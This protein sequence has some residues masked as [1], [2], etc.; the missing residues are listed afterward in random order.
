MNDDLSASLATADELSK[1]FNSLL[2]EASSGNN[3]TESKSQV[4]TH[5]HTCSTSFP[6]LAV[7]LH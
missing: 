2:Q 3:N 4:L 6:L 5:T 1:E 7:N